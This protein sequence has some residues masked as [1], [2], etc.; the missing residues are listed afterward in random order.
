MSAR[1]QPFGIAHLATLGA[2]A[3]ASAG[4]ALT[5]VTSPGRGRAVRRTLAALLP[6]SL[7]LLMFLD[8]ADGVSFR[9]YAPL[10]LCDLAVPLASYAL[11][12]GNALAFELTYTWSV[13]GTLPA[14]LTPD[15]AEGF[16]HFRFLLYFAQHGGLVVAAAALLASGLRPRP[17]TPLRSLAWLNGVALGVGLVDAASG[18]NF[19]YL[20]AKPGAQTPLDWF[21]PWP[22]YIVTC[23]LFALALFAAACA[24]LRKRA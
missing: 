21:G 17:G 11:L 18:A 12:T 4:A 19:M 15:V 5:M 10:Q 3:L 13:A 8:A 23:E 16:P 22:F 7:L 2:I 14:L 1:L 9:S 20:R 24:P 6:V